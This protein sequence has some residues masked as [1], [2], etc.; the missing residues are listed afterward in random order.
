MKYHK[1]EVKIDS[2]LKPPYF[3]GSML[4]GTFGYALKKVTCINPS[5]NCEGCFAKDNC[6]YYDFFEKQ[7]SFHPFRF[8]VK[9]GSENFN[10]SL[11]LFESACDKLPYILSV[12]HKEE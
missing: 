7:N 4:R 11:Y 6:L 5:Y 10:F 12:L 9:L 8:D 3:T 1:I 2:K